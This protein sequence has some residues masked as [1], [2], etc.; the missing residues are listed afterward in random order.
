[1]GLLYLPENEKT[2]NCSG[3]NAVADLCVSVYGAIRSS[4]TVAAQYHFYSAYP[5]TAGSRYLI[6]A[7]KSRGEVTA[8]KCSRTQLV[9]DADRDIAELNRSRTKK[10]GPKAF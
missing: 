10:S 9:N 2:C 4:A 8:H 6:Y 7:E 5:F 3:R 1:V